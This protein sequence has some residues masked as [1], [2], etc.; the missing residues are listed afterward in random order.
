MIAELRRN[1]LPI[2]VFTILF[3]LEL[4]A[5]LALNHGYFSYTLDDPYIHLAMAENIL[6]GHY[7]VNLSE[8]S[9]PSSSILWPFLLAPFAGISFGH[10]V[11]L[12][13]NFLSSIGIIMIFGRIIRQISDDSMIAELMICLMIPLS[14][15]IGLAFTGM[16]HSL[17]VFLAAAMALGMIRC[18]ENGTVPSWFCWVIIAGPLIRYENLAL[19]VPALAY[20][21]IQKQYQAFWVSSGILMLSIVGFSLFL[22]QLGLG[23]LPSSVVSKSTPV[24]HSGSLKYILINLKTNIAFREGGWLLLALFLCLCRIFGNQSASADKRLAGWIL[25]AIS[26]HFLFGRFGWFYRYEVYIWAAAIAMLLRLYA[27]SLSRFFNFEKKEVVVFLAFV[28]SLIIGGGYFQAITDT[29]LAANNIYEQHFQMHRFITEYYPK[30]AAVHDLGWVSYK[31]DRYILD[32][33]GLASEKALKNR[34]SEDPSWMNILAK[35]HDVKLAMVNDN[36][37]KPPHNWILIGRLHLGKTNI[38]P[39][40]SAV[41]FYVLDKNSIPEIISCLDQFVKTLPDGMKFVFRQ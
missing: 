38:T 2:T 5:I 4:S 30:P 1:I 13:I 28:L 36:W 7:G 12:V 32:L 21:L 11:P 25:T 10:Y 16:E 24:Y 31:N 26:L 18:E 41:T 14:N 29:P 19:S 15:L 8:Y 37:F 22:H 39:A 23:F 33:G 17:Q 3:V 34:W 20:L 40:N 6:K 27:P 35:Q 9:A